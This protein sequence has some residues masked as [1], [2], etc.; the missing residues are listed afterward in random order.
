MKEQPSRY[1]L[2]KSPDNKSTRTIR[3]ICSKLKIK[4]VELFTDFT[5]CSDVF[6]VDFEKGTAGKK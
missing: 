5:H 4:T 6:I 1:L 3:D 2:D